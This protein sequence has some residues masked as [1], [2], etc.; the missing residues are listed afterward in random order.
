MTVAC[1]AFFFNAGAGDLNSYPLSHFPTSTKISFTA[2]LDKEFSN[3]WRLILTILFPHFA[4][5]QEASA[6][7]IY[8]SSH[9]SRGNTEVQS[10][11]VL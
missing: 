1:S 6:M 2:F 3:S 11:L 8:L 10:Q 5:E 4:S 9:S 7:P